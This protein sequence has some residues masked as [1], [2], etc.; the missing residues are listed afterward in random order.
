ML[1]RKVVATTTVASRLRVRALAELARCASPAPLVPTAI[2]NNASSRRWTSS[3]TITTTTTD[4]SSKEELAK[5]SAFTTRANLKSLS[6]ETLANALT[7]K[8]YRAKGANVEHDRLRVLGSRALNFYI[9]EF[10]LAKYPSLPGDAVRSVVEAYV[11]PAALTSIGKS[12]GV[13]YVMKW[14]RGAE[15]IKTGENAVVAKVVDALI[16]ALYL[17]KG[18]QGVKEFITTHVLSRSV[19]VS[20][21]LKLN[22]PK[23]LLQL[24][25]KSQGK[26]KPVSRL[27]KETGRL[28]TAPVFIVGVYSG[29]EKIGEGYGS[30]LAMA[31]TRAAKNAI[32]KHFLEQVKDVTVPSDIDEL[33][34]TTTFLEQQ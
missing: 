25:V 4:E 32:E 3:S 19:D 24:I 33:E 10:V 23:Y 30:S 12:L 5:L 6:E 34:G 2:I 21:H 7:H 17:E 13:Q 22:N 31:E 26:P 15:D 20:A 28:S 9:T 18:R 11:G 8:S 27:L 14:K 1:L 16:G 29:L